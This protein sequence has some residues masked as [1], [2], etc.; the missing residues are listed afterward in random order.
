MITTNNKTDV[1]VSL[2]G[3][4]VPRDGTKKTTTYTVTFVTANARY[5]RLNTLLAVTKTAI[6]NPN[7]MTLGAR[8]YEC[9]HK[10]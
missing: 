8:I 2:R 10:H 7:T 5:H 3:Y 6:I 1:L 4:A 9:V